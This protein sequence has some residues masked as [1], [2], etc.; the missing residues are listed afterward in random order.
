MEE[1]FKLLESIMNF[2]LAEKPFEWET[3][4]R[5]EGVYVR[6]R[7]KQYELFIKPKLLFQ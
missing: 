7:P 5:K 3:P 2:S 6:F 1:N 4:H